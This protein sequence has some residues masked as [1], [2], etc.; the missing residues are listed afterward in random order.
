MKI[1]AL[2]VCVNYLDYFKA[3]FERWR[4]H[5]ESWTIVTDFQDAATADFAIQ[6]ELRLHRTNVLYERGAWFNQG[7]AMEEARQSMPWQDW[8]LF[9]DA[10]VVPEKK[11]FEQLIAANPLPGVIYG[12][13]RYNCDA[14]DID[15][16][17]KDHPLAATWTLPSGFFQLFHTSDPC[18]QDVPLIDTS[19][20]HAGVHDSTLAERWLE[21][22]RVKL[23]LRLYHLSPMVRNWCGRG[24]KMEFEGDDYRADKYR[25][26][27]S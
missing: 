2:T 5:L 15:D 1:N 13:D 8:C 22:Q 23:P 20:R 9:L 6:H 14:D 12:A 26:V 27:S 4:P 24:K 17:T 18:V 7:A 21:H 19:W 25:C 3:G 11:W 16:D 10:D